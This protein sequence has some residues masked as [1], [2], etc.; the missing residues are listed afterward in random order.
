[1]GIGVQVAVQDS[2]LV[3]VGPL[4]GT[5]AW[6]AGLRAGDRIIRIGDTN[7]SGMSINDAVS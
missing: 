3:I 6:R 1:M 4:Y 5:P 2:E 7:T